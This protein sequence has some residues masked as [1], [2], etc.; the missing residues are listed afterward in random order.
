MKK[1]FLWI[2]F[3]I[4]LDQ[5]SKFIITQTVALH[6]SIKVIDNFF[7]ITYVRNPNAGLG[8]FNFAGNM[9]VFYVVTVFAII[10]FT[11]LLK[12]IDFKNKK[13]YTFGIILLFAGAIGNFIDRIIFQ[14]VIDWLDFH[15]FGFDFWVFNIAD[16]C[17]DIG[18]ALFAIDI[19]FLEGKR[20][21][22][23][24]E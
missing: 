2:L 16:M 24:N 10:V 7:Y 14:Y 11:Y 17:L 9:V 21:K 12:D 23:L 6:E 15:I 1:A 13:I 5:I 22:N 20:K 3:F 4:L 18:I 19:L 8:G